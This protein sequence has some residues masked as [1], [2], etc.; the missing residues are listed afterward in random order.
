MET[1][2]VAQHALFVCSH[3][4]IVSFMSFIACALGEI[5][6]SWTGAG[7]IVMPRSEGSYNAI[8]HKATIVPSPRLE[9]MQGSSDGELLW[10]ECCVAAGRCVQ[11]RFVVQRS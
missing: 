9:T 5:T 7:V 1:I 3:I 10:L 6:D 4:S 11:A 2:H 8:G